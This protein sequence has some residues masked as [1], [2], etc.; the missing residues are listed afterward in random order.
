MLTGCLVS[1]WRINWQ[2]FP[3]PYPQLVQLLPNFNKAEM[4][5]SS[6]VVGQTAIVVVKTQVCRTH[7]THAE[8]LLLEAGCWH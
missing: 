7:L 5:F 2:Y 4:Q 6:K 8:L 3:Q 1:N